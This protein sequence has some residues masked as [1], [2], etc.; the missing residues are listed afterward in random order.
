MQEA[1]QTLLQDKYDVNPL[2]VPTDNMQS[3]NYK[4]HLSKLSDKGPPSPPFSLHFSPYNT[5]CACAG[6]VGEAG[7][8]SGLTLHPTSPPLTP[9]HTATNHQDHRGRQAPKICG[10]SGP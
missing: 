1:A 10:R 3:S 4:F 7:L 6:A 9:L 8:G 2:N 5:L